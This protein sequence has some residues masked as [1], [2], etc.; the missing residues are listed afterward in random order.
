MRSM[1]ISGKFLAFDFKLQLFSYIN[2]RSLGRLQNLTQYGDLDAVLHVGDFGY[3]L[4]YFG[5]EFFRAI[6]PVASRV[7]YMAL[8]GK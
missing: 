2:A 7:P 8:P 5:D 6:E 1:V 3:D 4:P